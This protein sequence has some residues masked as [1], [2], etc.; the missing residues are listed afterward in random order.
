MSAIIFSSW[1]NRGFSFG[2]EGRLLPTPPPHLGLHLALHCHLSKHVWERTPASSLI[3]PIF[4]LS[5][6]PL[7]TQNF[8]EQ[9]A[10]RNVYLMLGFLLGSLLL[11]PKQR[12]STFYIHLPF[13][14]CVNFNWSRS[15]QL[16]RGWQLIRPLKTETLTVLFLLLHLVLNSSLSLL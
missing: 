15:R 12:S 3:P 9:S 13:T 5:D 1:E 14:T 4:C 11:Y 10:C 7:Y 16:K 6:F 8:V 2:D